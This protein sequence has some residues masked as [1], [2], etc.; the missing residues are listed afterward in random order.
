MSIMATQRTVGRAPGDLLHPVPPRRRA[1]GQALDRRD[2][3]RPDGRAHA[4]LRVQAARARP[5]RPAPVRADE[6]AGGRGHRRA[7]RDRRHAGEGRVRPHRRRARRSSRPCARSSA[8]PTPGCSLRAHE[9]TAADRGRRPRLRRG[10]RHPLRAALVHGHPGPAEELLDQRPG[11]R[12]RLR[13]RDGLRR[14]VDHR[15][16]RD[17]GVG[18]DRHAG[19]VD[20]RDPAV[21]PGGQ[22]RGADVL[23]RRHAGPRALRGRPAPGAAAHARARRGDGLHELLRGPRARVLLLP[24]RAPRERRAG[25]ARRG[26]LLRPDHARR[27][28]RRAPR[29]RARARA[30]R[31]PRGVHPPRGR[32]EPARDRH[33]LR[34]RAED[35][36]RLHDLPHHGQGV[37]HE[38]RL[39]RDLHAEAAVRRERLRH[40]HAPV[41]LPRRARTRSTTRTTSTSSPTPARRS[42]PA[43]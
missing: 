6:G 1:G 25:G 23:R 24:E 13:G 32:A 5:V 43:S 20:L 26:R 16:Q 22:G 42:S 18:H 3:V 30:A 12:G 14:L 2:P 38:V 11:A 33:A 9:R 39:A 31:H 35:G 28:L 21:A 36:G 29:D 7:P 10:P 4:L 40:A 19:P 17:R 8:G 37:R 15:L 27:R 41:A 34:R